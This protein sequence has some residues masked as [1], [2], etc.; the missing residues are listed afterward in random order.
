MD[1]VYDPRDFEEV[2][3]ISNASVMQNPSTQFEDVTD[4]DL[5]AAMQLS[6]TT[7]EDDEVRRN[8]RSTPEPDRH[9]VKGMTEEEQISLAIEASSAEPSPARSVQ[10]A[11]E[12]DL[13]KAT[14]NSLDL[15]SGGGEEDFVPISRSYFSYDV[16]KRE[17]PLPN[18]KFRIIPS[19]RYHARSR[20]EV[21]YQKVLQKRLVRN[22][23]S[24]SRCTCFFFSIM[25]IMFEEFREA[26]SA[27]RRRMM[28]EMRDNLA[29]ALAMPCEM[30][31]FQHMN[32]FEALFMLDRQ[33]LRGIPI[34]E[35]TDLTFTLEGMQTLLRSADYIGNEMF[36]LVCKI[37]KLPRIFVF[38]AATDGTLFANAYTEDV[39]SD[40]VMLLTLVGRGNG[41][42]GHYE[43]VMIMTPNDEVAY[44]TM[45]I[46]DP[47][48]KRL[49]ACTGLQRDQVYS[50]PRQS[51]KR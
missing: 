17:P 32:N 35:G 25:F 49:L 13:C 19:L 45:K 7:F 23:A 3:Q 44:Q 12:E 48:F 30:P 46:S 5:L 9:W 15:T 20:G 51:K 1:Y 39:Y 16:A 41:D 29:D 2:S 22:A 28:K 47:G 34:Y 11:Y 36:S 14:Q 31:G 24:G 6:M 40:E 33:D 37:F 50:P 10:D 4:P 27:K 21:I 43:P 26:D 8:S 42:E 18:G 38:E